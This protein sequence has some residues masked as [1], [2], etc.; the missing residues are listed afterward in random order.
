MTTSKR[1]E[2][3]SPVRFWLR[4][5]GLIVLVLSI[6]IYA[7]LRSSWW[8]FGILLLVPDASILFYLAGTRVGSIAYNTVHSYVIP[9]SASILAVTLGRSALLPFLMIWTAHIGMDRALGYGLKYP[10]SFRDTH[11]G[12]IGS[13][14]GRV[15]RSQNGSGI[16]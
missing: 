9:L 1:L 8:I 2:V 14:G 12:A 15:F 7:H 4:A 16:E 3:R 10:G 11:L 6:I 13:G 5:E